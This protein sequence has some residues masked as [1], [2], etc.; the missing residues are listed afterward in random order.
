[1]R[2][3]NFAYCMQHDCNSCKNQ[4]VCEEAER[5][6]EV[7]TIKVKPNAKGEIFITLY[8]TKYQIVVENNK[9]KK[10]SELDGKE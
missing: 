2:K 3:Y 8:G 5:K 1:M 7:K 4:R 6:M 9:K 10:E